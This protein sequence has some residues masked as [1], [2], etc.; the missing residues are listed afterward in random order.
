MTPP[1]VTIRKIEMD[2]EK[3]KQDWLEGVAILNYR[4]SIRKGSWKPKNL[5]STGHPLIINT[6]DP[7]PKVISNSPKRRFSKEQR[8]YLKGAYWRYAVYGEMDS[9]EAYHAFEM[10]SDL[11]G[12][13]EAGEKVQTKKAANR[14]A[15]RSAENLAE[16]GYVVLSYGEMKADTD[17]MMWNPNQ[18]QPVLMV[19]ATMA[20]AEKGKELLEQDGY[21]T[22]PETLR[23]MYREHMAAR[24]IAYKGL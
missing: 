18:Y 2:E 23:Q 7:N 14:S 21:T 5:E 22:D 20:A 24:H 16:Y 3:E 4:R 10:R 17:D 1:G 11:R 9:T 15:K 8:N 13:W 6:V 12:D 19:T